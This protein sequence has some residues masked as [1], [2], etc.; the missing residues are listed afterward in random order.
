[1]EGGANHSGWAIVNGEDEASGWTLRSDESESARLKRDRRAE[2]KQQTP[3]LQA[4][5]LAL[6]QHMQCHCIPILQK[7]WNTTKY[8]P[9]WAISL[10]HTRR[11][12]EP[13]GLVI[14]LGVVIA[15]SSQNPAVAA[16]L[17]TV[18]VASSNDNGS[19]NPRCLH[20]NSPQQVEVKGDHFSSAG[21]SE[22]E[23][24]GL[25]KIKSN[26]YLKK[27]DVI[28]EKLLATANAVINPSAAHHQIW[29]THFRNATLN[30]RIP[31]LETATI[32][33]RALL[34]RDL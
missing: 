19:G 24:S 22:S 26:N 33:L 28:V 17:G 11:S 21:L 15:A 32:N 13:F 14:T 2:L 6:D 5:R 27:A 10:P 18:P 7:T 16:A 1:M 3:L 30:I 9:T 8:I 20:A 23:E 31:N 12:L 34:P 4:T 29:Y 25:A